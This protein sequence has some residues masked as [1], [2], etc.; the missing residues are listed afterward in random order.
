MTA[1]LLTFSY[2]GLIGHSKSVWCSV[3][4]YYLL[5]VAHCP[6]TIWLCNFKDFTSSFQYML[7]HCVLLIIWGYPQKQ[8]NCHQG[9]SLSSRIW[10]VHFSFI[11]AIPYC[12]ITVLK[13]A[14]NAQFVHHSKIDIQKLSVREFSCHELNANLLWLGTFSFATWLVRNQSILD[15]RRVLEL[16]R[17]GCCSLT[18]WT[19]FLSSFPDQFNLS[20]HFIYD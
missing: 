18:L 19:P 20:G 10:P 7:H 5:G 16:G 11:I 1:M 13:L 12:I 6:N 17:Y 2:N 4:L 9:L 3:L 8:L 14:A 15:G